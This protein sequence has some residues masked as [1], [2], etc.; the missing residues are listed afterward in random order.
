MCLYHESCLE[1]NRPV[2]SPALLFL[3]PQNNALGRADHGSPSPLPLAKPLRTSTC[4]LTVLEGARRA[5]HYPYIHP[6][7]HLSIYAPHSLIGDASSPT[8]YCPP[9]SYVSCTV[10][11]CRRRT[12]LHMPSASGGAMRWD[13]GSRY[14]LG[15]APASHARTVRGSSSLVHWPV[16]CTCTGTYAVVHTSF[17]Y[18]QV[19]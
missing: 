15:A 17:M 12:D 14:K 13:S 10:G 6:F 4:L 2:R 18:L 11:V 19:Q 8:S 1:Q 9:P 7:I 16:S 3:L 5:V